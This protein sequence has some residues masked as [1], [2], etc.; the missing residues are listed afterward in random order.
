MSNKNKTITAIAL[1]MIKVLPIR[2]RDIVIKRFGLKNQK[3]LT[4]EAIG[5][6]YG[7]TRE[8]VRQIEVDALRQLSHPEVISSLEHH[9]NNFYDHF[10]NHGHAVAEHSF[11][12]NF[13][14]SKDHNSIIFA[15]IL[16]NAFFKFNENEKFH[17]TWFT[18]NKF[19][20]SAQKIVGDLVSELESVKKPISGDEILSMAKKIAQSHIEKPTEKIIH[21]YIATSKEISK[22]AFGDYGLKIWPDINPKGVRDKAYLTLKRGNK[23]LHFKQVADLINQ[24]GFDK[25]KAHCQTVHNELIKDDRFVLV[26]RGLYGLREWGYEPGTVVDVL[27]TIF[28]L[29]KKPLGLEEIVKK[30]LEKRFVKE[31]TIFLN[32]QNK[33]L[34]KKTDKGEYLLS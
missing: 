21:S 15:L 9:Y 1:E 25:R 12:N 32:L 17:L 8:R 14:D 24:V 19:L 34:F 10:K 28:E 29:S 27:K 26:G 22:N 23:P 7:I 31:N 18:D 2:T 20:N 13:G 6:E 16:G 11:L 4:L 30:V 5:W 33:K 3:P